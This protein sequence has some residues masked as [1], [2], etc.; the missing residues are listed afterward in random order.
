MVFPV[1]WLMVTLG[2]NSLRPRK[3][4][5]FLCLCPLVLELHCP[6]T[7]Q[8]CDRGAFH[9]SVPVSSS[10]KC[11]NCSLTD[12]MEWLKCKVLC[13]FPVLGV[14]NGV[15]AFYCCYCCP[16]PCFVVVFRSESC[17]VVR[18]SLEL[19]CHPGMTPFFLS[20]ASFFLGLLVCY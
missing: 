12:G 15:V 20:L 3:S 2:A 5:F 16:Y 8:S 17:Y 14:K 11:I 1:S 6:P 7:F 13:L 4:A 18:A 9:H 19:L 10:T